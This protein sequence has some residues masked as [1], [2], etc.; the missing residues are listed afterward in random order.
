MNRSPFDEF[1]T[2]RLI[3]DQD[4]LHRNAQRMRAI[5]D[6]HGVLL[7]PHV[8]TNKCHEIAEIATAGRRSGITVSTLNEV[9]Y[10]ARAGYSDILYAV[11]ITPNKFPRV[12]SLTRDE[13]ADI[14][15]LTDSIN[16]LE[17]ADAYARLRE[18]HF[19]FLIEIDCGEHRCGVAPGSD[20]VTAMARYAAAS[21]N[22]DFRGVLTHAG[23]SYG[24][25]DPIAIRETAAQEVG[26]AVQAAARIRE[27]GIEVPIVSIG[28]TPTVLYAPSMAGVTEVRPGVYLFF[29]LAQFSRGIC[30]RDDIALSVLA[31]VIGH[32]RTVNSLSLDAGAL[33]L[34]K[35]LGANTFL[36]GIGYGQVCDAVTLDPLGSLTVGAVHQEHGT[37]KLPAPEWF[38]RLPIGAMV[39]ILPNHACMTAAAYDRYLVLEN[40]VPKTEWR[41][42]NGW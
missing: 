36:P 12:E 22:L 25:D 16:V 29:D 34:S 37:V 30:G 35:D 15:L 3:L 11:G 38:D 32:N 42:T 2:P 40:G 17:A 26:S 6:G 20:A 39:R 13:G 33:A 31:T 14:L 18:I 1:D 41:R 27:C 21:P 4:R 8:K 23:H 7:R 24:S 5:A 28:S 9:E 10:F 19:Y